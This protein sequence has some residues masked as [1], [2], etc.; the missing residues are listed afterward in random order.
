MT[1]TLIGIG[2]VLATAAVCVG[3]DRKQ[4]KKLSIGW[5]ERVAQTIQELTPILI[6]MGFI[7]VAIRKSYA[8]KKQ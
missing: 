2:V 6:L 4:R 7:A 3:L 1:L 8:S 5:E